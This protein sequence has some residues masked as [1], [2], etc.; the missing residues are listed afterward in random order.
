MPFTNVLS[1]RTRLNDLQT[2]QAVSL[3]EYFPFAG[4]NEEAFC[5]VQ[6]SLMNALLSELGNLYPL[7]NEY[8]VDSAKVSRA[9]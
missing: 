3:R 2:D 6:N 5:Y 1:T 8:R 4:R 9:T 7:G